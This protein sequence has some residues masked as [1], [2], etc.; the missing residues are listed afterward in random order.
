MKVPRQVSSVI[1]RGLRGFVLAGEISF[2]LKDTPPERIKSLGVH[3]ISRP[4]T[5]PTYPRKTS[6]HM[7]PAFLG[8]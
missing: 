5:L 1:E 6:W 7:L 4:L 2:K 3:N 8:Q